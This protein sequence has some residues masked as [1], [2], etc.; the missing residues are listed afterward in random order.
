VSKTAV[1]GLKYIFPPACPLCGEVLEDRQGVACPECIRRIHFV[2]NPCCAQCG[3]EIADEEA[4]Y[5]DACGEKKRSYIKG[6]P[7]VEYDDEINPCMMAFKYGG[8]KGYA[9]FLASLIVKRQGQAILDINPDVLVPVPVHKERLKKRG[10]NQAELLA[11]S[12]SRYFGIPYDSKLLI[13]EKNTRALK[14]MDGKAREQNLKNAFNLVSKSVEYSRVL[15]VDDIYTTG[16]TIEECTRV[17][18]RLGLQGVYYTS[19]CIG[20]GC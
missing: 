5:C 8:K 1:E 16:A 4:E 18:H 7:A 13:R 9:D 17:L 19:V 3:R 2:G 10:Y 11:K 14:T 20:K 6:F 15:L 12:L